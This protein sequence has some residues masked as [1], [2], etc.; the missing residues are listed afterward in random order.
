MR[1]TLQSLPA[2]LRCGHPVCGA[3]PANGPVQ[4]RPQGG[5]RP[6]VL[7][8]GHRPP[9]YHDFASATNASASLEAGHPAAERDIEGRVLLAYN[10]GLPV[11][12]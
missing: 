12:G 7:T 8:C 9:S 1:A 5:I 4:R 6:E 11:G 10:R 3:Q 2:R